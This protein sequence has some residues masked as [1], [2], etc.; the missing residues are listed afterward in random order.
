M[1]KN[2][3]V[4]DR[5]SKLKK[6][7]E[8]HNYNYYVLSA[9]TISDSEYDY[10]VKELES[11]GESSKVGSDLRSSYKREKKESNED[12]SNVLGV[13]KQYFGK[14]SQRDKR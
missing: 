5:I 12:I 1:L 13:P 4:K 9:P 2:H 6:A 8:K 7:I 14:E 3:N 10:L 11:L